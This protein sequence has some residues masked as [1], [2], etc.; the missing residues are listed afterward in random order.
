GNGGTVS[1]LKARSP[2]FSTCTTGDAT[3]ALIASLSTGGDV[4]SRLQP[5]NDIAQQPK[6][7]T[8]M[9][10]RRELLQFKLRRSIG[11][12]PMHFMTLSIKRRQVK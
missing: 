3:S 2:S 1:D 11:V 12:L 4:F 10:F 9:I 6:V 7:A 8:L 5:G